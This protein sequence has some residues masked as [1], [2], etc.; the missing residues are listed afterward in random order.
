MDSIPQKIRGTSF[1]KMNF[2]DFCRRFA[3]ATLSRIKSAGGLSGL[4]QTLAFIAFAVIKINN[5]D[6]RQT[7]RLNDF[8]DLLM[9]QDNWNPAPRSHNPQDFALGRAETSSY[10][11][12]RFGVSSST[13]FFT[14]LPKSMAINP[15]ISAMLKSSPAT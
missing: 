12:F 5:R 11:R 13:R 6:F 2:H 14:T 3:C 9:I 1:H 8:E 10:H 4:R 15:A 7:S